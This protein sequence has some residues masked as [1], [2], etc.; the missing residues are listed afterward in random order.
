MAFIDH[1]EFDENSINEVSKL[2]HFSTEV[3][4]NWPVVYV[5]NNDEE[6]YVGETV[7]IARRME[8][9]LQTEERQRL[10]EINVVS[11]KTFNKSAILDLESFLI[12]Y[13]SS[14]GKYRLQNGNS[15][16]KDHEYYDRSE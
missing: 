12:R 1:Y 6:A 7:N 15:G 4:V 3:G 2:R 16:I 9:H 14:D 5:I 11:D 13:M 10:T 8:Q